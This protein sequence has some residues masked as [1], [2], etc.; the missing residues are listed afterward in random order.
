MKQDKWNEILR[1]RNLLGLPE[2]VTRKEIVEA[3]REKSRE[4]HP[5]TGSGL[6]N[7]AMEELNWAYK[8]IMAYVD[9]YKIK[10]TRTEE[11]MNEEEWWMFHFGQDPIWSGDKEE[12]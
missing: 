6:T 10:L 1:A 3:Y 5:D 4:I 2:E 8:F 7:T 12:S 11:G 9:H